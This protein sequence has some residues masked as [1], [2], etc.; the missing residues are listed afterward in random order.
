MSFA[1]PLPLTPA[2]SSAA[3]MLAQHPAFPRMAL[4][5]Q[6]ARLIAVDGTPL[7]VIDRRFPL[8]GTVRAALQAR[9]FGRRAGPCPRPSG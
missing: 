9:R 1:R 8:I 6:D 7:L 2:A 3:V 4:M 5:G